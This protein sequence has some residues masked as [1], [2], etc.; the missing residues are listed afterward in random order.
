MEK[1]GQ[2]NQIN[3]QLKKYLSPFP[4]TEEINYQVFIDNIFDLKIFGGGSLVKRIFARIDEVELTLIIITI[5]RNL[6]YPV[7][8]GLG[9]YINYNQEII[10]FYTSMVQLYGQLYGQFYEQNDQAN[11]EDISDEKATIL[12]KD[13]LVELKRRIL[14]NAP[15]KVDD[16]LQ[17]AYNLRE[18]DCVEEHFRIIKKLND[19][20]N[21]GKFRDVFS[22]A[23]NI[24][25][26]VMPELNARIR[27][28]QKGY[29]RIK[30]EVIIGSTILA[31]LPAFPALQALSQGE[32]TSNFGW[33]GAVALNILKGKYDEKLSR[34]LT[35]LKFGRNT[36]PYLIW[37]HEKRG[38]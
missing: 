17:F 14:Y 16:P 8:C 23:K 5:F 9:G 32:I 31:S 4:R 2:P 29:K 28:I 24:K 3:N 30:Y 19:D 15:W 6:M 20:F 10:S 38:N 36:A 27:E 21:E 25:E 37:E 34:F 33:V 22:G 35:G 13:F 12:P 1:Y 18:Y 11:Q 7:I 26:Q